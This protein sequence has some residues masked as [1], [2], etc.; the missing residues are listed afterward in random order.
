MSAVW[1]TTSAVGGQVPGQVG[2]GRLEA[3]QRADGQLAGGQDRQ[4]GPAVP[5][6]GGGVGEPGH[7][8]EQRPQRHVLPERHQPQLVVAADHT[9]LADQQGALVDAAAG[10]PLGVHVGQDRPAGGPGGGGQPGQVARV[11][12]RVAADAALAPDDQVGPGAGRE[13]TARVPLARN[14]SSTGPTTPGWTNATRAVPAG[15]GAGR[16]DQ[17]ASAAS[18]SVAATTAAAARVGPGTRRPTAAATATLTATSRKLSPQTPPRAA[19]D[20]SAGAFHWLAPSS[21]QGPPSPSQGAQRLAGHERARDQHQGGGQPLWPRPDGAAEQGPGEPAEGQPGHGQEHGQGDH[22]R[23]DGGEQEGVDGQ[24]EPGPAEPGPDRRLTPARGGH[25]QQQH[26]DQ[27]GQG[28]PPPSRP[29]EGQSQRRP[30]QRR[31]QPA[32]P[33]THGRRRQ[34]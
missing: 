28:Q 30:R 19:T 20:S 5:V 9:G 21:P 26:R 18:G 24:E 17:K 11:G 6:D 13:G 27:P 29:G 8:A 12:R 34:R 33:P 25:G 1:T 22:E 3:D 15:A 10:L 31:R 2:E 4:A 32:A 7:P 23:P 14:R 16:S